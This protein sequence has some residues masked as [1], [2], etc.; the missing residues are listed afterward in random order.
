MVRTILQR[1]ILLPP[2]LLLTNFISFAYAHL[3]LP[4]QINNNPFSFTDG[5]LAE[6][7]S[8]AYWNYL[9]GLLQLDLGTIPGSGQGPIGE[10]L[11]Q[12]CKASAGLLIIVI[13]LSVLLGILFGM[14]AAKAEPP[15]VARWLTFISTLGLAMPSFYLGSLLIVGSILYALHSDPGTPPLLPLQGFG[16]DKH[17]VLP[18]LVLTARPT[19]EIAQLTSSLMV[20]EFGKQYLVTALSYGHTW[21]S[22]RWRHV[23]RNILAPIIVTISRSFRLLIG[24]LILVEYLFGWP[25]IGRMLASALAPSRITSSTSLATFLYPPIIAATVT[26]LAAIFLLSDLGT[27]ILVQVFDPRLRATEEEVAG[28]W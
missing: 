26:L 18:L 27:S 24:E 9:L 2:A 11:L 4:R 20:G 19:M 1:L 3:S 10:A 12:A 6:P 5:Q 21:R 8:T 28:S 17:M 22:V 7:L 16:W 25:G 14:S 15:K 23:F 13:P